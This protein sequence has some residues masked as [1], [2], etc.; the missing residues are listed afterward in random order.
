MLQSYDLFLHNCNNFTNDFAMFLVGRSIPEQITSLPQTVLDTPFGQM[1]KPQLENSIR[2]ITQAPIPSYAV[3]QQSQLSNGASVPINLK[4]NK[5]NS[6]RNLHSVGVVHN[7]TKQH[8]IEELLASAKKSCAIIFFT[9][10]T[11]PPCKIV[12][13]AYDE[14]AAEADNK[15]IFIKVD[16]SQAYEVSSKYQVRVTPTF[17]TFLKGEKESEWSGAH[18]GR[19]RSNVQLLIQMAHPPHPHTNMKLPTLQRL[20][21]KPVTYTK[22]PPLDKLIK[23]LGPLST[24]E[25]I[26]A[27]KDFIAARD[28]FGAAES[29]LP[30][31][32]ATSEFIMSSLNDLEP[33]SL[34]PIVD[35]FR[36][37]LVDPRVSGYFAEESSHATV[38][39]CLH[40][41]SILGEDCPYPL[42]IVTLQMACNLFTSQ[43]FPPQLLGNSAVSGPLVQLV[44]SSLLD[45]SHPPICVAAA[46]LA[47]NIAA[48]NHLQRLDGTGDVLPEGAQ[49]EL[50]ASLL[51]ALGRTVETKDELRGL[52][53]AVGL[54]A[55]SS[56]K[57]EEVADLCD[58]LGAKAIISKV[59]GSFDELNALVAEVEMVL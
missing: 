54:F 3:P 21:R 20:H 28:K 57:D 16:I 15:A 12:Y 53:L 36:L 27:L 29:P 56:P 30:S 47:Y 41:I 24:N 49:V 2:G 42:R 46:S 5:N 35:L 44:T 34:F 8:E 55:Y 25:S 52:L 18:E 37:A 39:A 9:S 40:R 19:L 7:I 14:L 13:P 6:E 43:L 23:K 22:I 51:E 33:S 26:N 45:T 4:E 38:T 50:M 10:A 48:F 31:L 17:I 11:C 32:P 59:K 58:A 1:L